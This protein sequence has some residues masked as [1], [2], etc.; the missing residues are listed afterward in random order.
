MMSAAALE[1]GEDAFT[2]TCDGV[3]DV[4]GV[5][6]PCHEKEGHGPEDLT[7]SLKNSCN[8][9]FIALGERLGKD[10]IID[11]AYLMGLGGTKT[12]YQNQPVSE[13]NLPVYKNLPAE[14]ANLSIGQGDVQVTP[15]QVAGML[16]VIAN[17]GKKRPLNVVA[18]LGTRMEKLYWI[19]A[20][21]VG[22]R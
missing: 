14:I 16:D 9:A 11:T 4:G 18:E 3:I 22:S 5:Q 2:Y 15:F 8:P 1:A 13:G 17:E 6:I 20:E 19:S 7:L 21:R 12:A 10:R